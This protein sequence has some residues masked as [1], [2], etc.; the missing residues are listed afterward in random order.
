[1]DIMLNVNKNFGNFN[2]MVNVGFS[3]ED[4]LIIG[5]GIGGKLFIVFNLFFVYNFD[6]VFGFGL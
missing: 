1:M 6:L 2:L 3:Y 4:Y 5:M